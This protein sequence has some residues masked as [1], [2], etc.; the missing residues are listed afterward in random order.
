MSSIPENVVDKELY[1]KAKRIAKSKFKVWPSAYGS[2][3]LV[4]TYKSLGGRYRGKKTNDGLERWFAEKWVDVCYY[5]EI[6]EC[7]RPVGGY[8]D[9]KKA[10]PYCRPLKRISPQTPKTVGEISPKE[11]KK[12]CDSKRKNPEKRFISMDSKRTRNRR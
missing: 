3:Y 2:A 7:G 11:L 8:E 4:K 9:Y 5:P 12:R 6:V 10:Y 1:M